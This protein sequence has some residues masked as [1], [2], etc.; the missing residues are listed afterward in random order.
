[1]KAL[2][3]GLHSLVLAALNIGCIVAGF[4]VYHLLRPANQ[5]AVQVPVAVISCV[6]GFVLWTVVLWHL[7]GDN[8]SLRGKAEFA[9]TF[10]LAL[11]WS[12]VLFVPL[13]FVTQGYLT[14]AGNVLGIWLFQ[15]PTNAVAIV[16]ARAVTGAGP[17]PAF[18]RPAVPSSDVP[19][20]K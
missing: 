3:I 13:H 17:K 5:L 10:V 19:G 11:L 15:A 8:L 4:S 14:S 18:G 9:W 12:L 1:M 6:A 7:A 16:A 20:P 2:R